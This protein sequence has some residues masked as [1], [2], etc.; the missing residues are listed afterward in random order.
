MQR[1]DVRE[2][3]ER[4]RVGGDRVEVQMRDRLRRAV[5][6][7]QGL[8]D[9]DLGIGEE[10]VQVEA[11]VLGVAGDVVVAGVDVRPSLTR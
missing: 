9:V 11:R 1:G 4:L 10:R 3:D 7:L 2:A 6:A 5:T 8:D